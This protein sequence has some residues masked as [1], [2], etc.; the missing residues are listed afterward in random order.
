MRRPAVCTTCLAIVLAALLGSRQKDTCDVKLRLVD[1]NTG[2]E[3]P[4]LSSVRRRT[5]TPARD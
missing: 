4:G 1:S 2:S 5:G 3:L